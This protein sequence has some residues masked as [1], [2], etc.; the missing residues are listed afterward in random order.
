MT[1]NYFSGRRKIHPRGRLHFEILKKHAKILGQFYLLRFPQPVD[2]KRSA[3][4]TGN[5]KQTH[6]KKD[7]KTF[8][9]IAGDHLTP[10]PWQQVP[11]PCPGYIIMRRGEMICR[12]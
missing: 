12:V 7:K 5:K 6:Q 10:V 3:N 4:D 8:F 9:N 2:R 1:K 11:T